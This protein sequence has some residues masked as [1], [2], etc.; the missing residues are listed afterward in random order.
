[1]S[2]PQP[3][4]RVLYIESKPLTGLARQA[5]IQELVE[6]ENGIALKEVDEVMHLASDDG[7]DTC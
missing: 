6:M 1:M 3:E 5:R 7:T 4:C 2:K